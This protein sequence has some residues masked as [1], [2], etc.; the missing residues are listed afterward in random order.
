MLCK[1]TPCACA[2]CVVCA[3]LQHKCFILDKCVG[4]ITLPFLF[5][6]LS[7]WRAILAQIIL[8]DHFSDCKMF[9]LI[10]G[11]RPMTIRWNKSNISMVYMAA[12]TIV[13]VRWP[14]LVLFVDHKVR[15]Q[16]APPRQTF[17]IYFY[18][19]WQQREKKGNNNDI[20]VSLM[21]RCCLFSVT[22]VAVVSVWSFLTCV[23]R[24]ESA[25]HSVYSSKVQNTESGSPRPGSNG[26]IL[27]V[28]T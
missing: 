23:I 18:A 17:Y 28:Y 16:A 27:Q 25:L 14:S 2:L 1:Y 6:L 11:S 15:I 4:G 26:F 13:I 9:H 20:S 7:N 24:N 19:H 12:L 21:F 22:G 5:Y 3:V 10:F 8:K